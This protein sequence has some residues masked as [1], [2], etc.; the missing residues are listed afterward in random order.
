VLGAQTLG[1]LVGHE[2]AD[3]GARP[4]GAPGDQAAHR[5]QHGHQRT[6]CVAGAAR[7]KPGAVLAQAEGIA[8]PAV[9]RRDDV[10]MRVEGE[11]RAGPVLE[12]ARDID[13][14]RLEFD[15]FRP[16]AHGLQL[17]QDELRRFPFAARRV[18]RVETHEI[19]ERRLQAAGFGRGSG[20]GSSP[21]AG[22][23]MA[24]N[25]RPSELPLFPSVANS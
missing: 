2:Y 22:F 21:Q 6:L 4:P 7:E 9:A 14:A 15:G 5:F 16:A 8:R 17:G 25:R 11:G 12:N 3:Q 24:L 23:V 18:L 19:V 13:P 1:F 20:H 10:E